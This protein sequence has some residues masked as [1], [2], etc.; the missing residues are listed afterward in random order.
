[1]QICEHSI[2][3]VK[4]VQL[5]GGKTVDGNRDEYDKLIKEF[6]KNL[7]NLPDEDPL[8]AKRFINKVLQAVPFYSRILLL[9][10]VPM[11]I[12]KERYYG[13]KTR[14]LP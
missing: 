1:M 10:N 8:H 3:I 11:N 4:K 2:H 13:D 9:K 7:L 14:V 5:I 12:N 6:E